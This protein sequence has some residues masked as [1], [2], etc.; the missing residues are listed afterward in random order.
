L[1]FAYSHFAIVGHV[2]GL[3]HDLFTDWLMSKPSAGGITLQAG[4]PDQTVAFI[5]G[6]VNSGSVAEVSSIS[7]PV[8]WNIRIPALYGFASWRKC[9][10]STTSSIVLCTC[11]NLGPYNI[12]ATLTFEPS[13]VPVCIAGFEVEQFYALF[14]RRLSAH[15]TFA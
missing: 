14:N 12:V 4:R 11:A 3:A 6:E 7:N 13:L 1:R 9:S 5:A 2:R 15:N 10:P 8:N